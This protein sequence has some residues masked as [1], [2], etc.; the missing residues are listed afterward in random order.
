MSTINISSLCVLFQTASTTT[1]L[2][3]AKTNLSKGRRTKKDYRRHD[4]APIVEGMI[5]PGATVLTIEK[6][7]FRNHG[8]LVERTDEFIFEGK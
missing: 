4:V 5:T 7:K 2:K 6:L 1:S 8:Q 3:K